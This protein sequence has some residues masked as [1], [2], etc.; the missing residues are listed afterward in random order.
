A[1]TNDIAQSNSP[2]QT[3]ARSPS[4]NR[5]ASDVRSQADDRQTR[6]RDRESTGRAES[7]ALAV[8]TEP[9]SARIQANAPARSSDNSG[10][11]DF[12]NFA[13]IAQRNIFDPDRRPH[14]VRSTGPV[15]RAPRVES[16]ALVGVMSYDKGTFAFF[17]GTR[18]D[19][20]KALKVDD[21]IAGYRVSNIDAETV[22]L[23]A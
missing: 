13:L 21:T 3:T 19:Y 17:D 9:R 12:S 23:A 4:Q 1:S 8:D 18:S 15:T 10:R 2:S 22:K 6:R 7:S 11:P 5:A 16:F 20:Q 14:E